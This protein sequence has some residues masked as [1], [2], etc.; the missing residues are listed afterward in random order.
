M[1]QKI[2]PSPQNASAMTTARLT[3]EIKRIPSGESKK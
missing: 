1:D 3:H 2:Q